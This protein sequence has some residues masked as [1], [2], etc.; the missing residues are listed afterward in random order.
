MSQEASFF[1]FTVNQSDT[2]TEQQESSQET[3][4]NHQCVRQNGIK[5]IILQQHNFNPNM[6][7]LNADRLGSL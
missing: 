5:A 2:L 7:R 1:F 6:D 4:P 3:K